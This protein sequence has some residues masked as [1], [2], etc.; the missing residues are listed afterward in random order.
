MCCRDRKSSMYNIHTAYVNPSRYTSGTRSQAHTQ[1]AK[2][3]TQ[4]ETADPSRKD[5]TSNSKS[6]AKTRRYTQTGH[7]FPAERSTRETCHA[8]AGRLASRQSY[9]SKWEGGLSRGGRK[10]EERREGEEKAG[11][12]TEEGGRAWRRLEG[13]G[14]SEDGRMR[15]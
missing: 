12:T 1:I 2:E 9:I 8:E 4:K 11:M 5:P 3:S 6:H 14:R 10:E 13:G 15:K 7:H